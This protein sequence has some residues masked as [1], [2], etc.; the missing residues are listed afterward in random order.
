MR[1]T[2]TR[3]AT[4]TDSAR[5]A[6]LLL[7]AFAWAAPARASLTQ[8]ETEQV[9]GYVTTQSH[10]D[11][12]RAFV[13]RPDLTPDESAAAMSAALAGTTLDDRMVAY[14]EEVVLGAPSVATRPVLAAAIARALL[15]RVDAIYAQH[16]ADLDRNDAAL[17]QVARAYGF[18]AGEVSGADSSMTDAGRADIAKALADHVARDASMLHFDVQLPQAVAKV[19]A[20]AA[21]ALLD[22]M[23]DGVT[24]RVDAADKLGLAGPRRA[25]LIE[26]GLLVMDA[27]GSD[28]RVAAVRS[29]VTQLPGA[30][31]G[32]EAVY[33]G[34]EH[35]AFKSRAPVVCTAD[36]NGA[37]GEAASPW[38]GEADPPPVDA[39]T[40][41]I[42]RG[43]AAAA[44]HRALERRPTLRVQVEHDGGEAG[45]STFAAMLVVD[46]T[47][48]VEVAAARL[49]AGKAESAAWLADAVGALGAFAPAADAKDGLSIPVGRAK[50]THVTLEPS[51]AASAFRLD[52]HAWRIDRD[53]SGAASGMKRDGVPVATPMLA[54][55]HAVATEGT[56]WKGAGMVFARLAGAPRVAIAAGPRVRVVG[57]S[58][59]DAVSTPAPAD[60]VTLEVDL[61]VDDA[62][63]GIAVRAVPGARG[64]HGVS[65]LVVPGTK[66]KAALLIGD[67]YGDETAVAPA[68]DLTPGSTVHVV[69]VA[70]GNRVDATVGGRTLSVTVPA[71]YA[72]GDVALR[73][74][75]GATVEA[76]HWSLLAPGKKR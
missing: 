62:P 67:G 22:A 14:L 26:L 25:A 8:S 65:L 17:S 74:Y 56:S 37:L 63:G 68:V 47:R 76:S 18:I 19:R 20:Q 41:A 36:A 57:S 31:E 21:V 61:R 39:A 66:P 69:L 72:H 59:A 40:M 46:A 24:R 38:S 48:T 10:P 51:G 23:P 34:D 5:A 2:R 64:L 43:L 49:L 32:A 71:D 15:G 30:R 60:D 33:V 35:A 4:R 52:T 12:V 53:G 58:A 29:L 28:D 70:Q 44:V 9:R 6:A 27:G 45:V 42:A 54:S 11:R 75:P 16:P 7:A 3:R 73:A 13:A 1:T 50:M 55:V